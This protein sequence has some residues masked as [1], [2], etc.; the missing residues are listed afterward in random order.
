MEVRAVWGFGGVTNVSK[1]P[2]R[3]RDRLQFGVLSWGS[4]DGIWLLEGM[5]L[6]VRGKGF[7]WV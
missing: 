7:S 6:L 5:W 1:E 2:H 3:G 4:G